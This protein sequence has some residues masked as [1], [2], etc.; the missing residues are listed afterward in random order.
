M[1]NIYQLSP[2]LYS[3]SKHCHSPSTTNTTQDDHPNQADMECD[4]DHTKMSAHINM[5]K[6]P[7]PSNTNTGPVN[8]NSNQMS[9][10]SPTT[11]P[12]TT[13]PLPSPTMW[14]NL[15]TNVQQRLPYQS[16]SNLNQLFG[17]DPANNQSSQ[18]IRIFFQN[19]NGLP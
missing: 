12:N 7:Q 3:P 1:T 10:T 2:A 15:T 6:R 13:R 17:D 14:P 8:H 9:T 19:V 4:S 11:L 18:H 16:G 5:L